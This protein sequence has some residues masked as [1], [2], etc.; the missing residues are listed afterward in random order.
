MEVRM[1]MKVMAVIFL[2]MCL[3]PRE[4]SIRLSFW[5]KIVVQAR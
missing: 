2:V 5:W 4:S 3:L 1:K